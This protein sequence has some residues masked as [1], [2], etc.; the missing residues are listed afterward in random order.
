MLA[1][2]TPPR[3]PLTW[4]PTLYLAQ[5]LPFFAVNMVALQMFK[6][7]GIPNEDATFWL[8][9]IGFAWVFK[10]LWSP[11]LELVPTRKRVVVLFELIGGT[12]LG[13][14]ALA[15]HVPAYFAAC[16]AVLAV[17]AFA[18]ATHDIGADGIY[19]ASL[20]E[21]QQ[22]EY[23]GW[24]GA[25]FNAGKFIAS[26]GLLILAGNLEKTIGVTSAWTIIFI[27]IGVAMVGLG[28]YHAWALPP[29]P[30][31]ALVDRSAKAISATLWHVLLD[32]FRKPGI[33]LA[34]IFI[35][36]FRA[37]EAQV[38]TIGPLFLREARALG[39]L[40][41]TT[42]E[43]GGVYGTAGTVAF[44]LGSIGGGYFTARLGLKRAIFF[45]ILTMNL[46][47]LVFYY[48]S[49]VLPTDL[50]V[51]TVALSIEMFGYGFG[52]VGLILFMMQVVAV[53]KYQ[54]A[55][56]AF[57]TG[58]MQLGFV[59]FGMFSGKIQVALGYQHFFIWT[60][61]AAIPVLLLS[62]IMPIRARS[63]ADQEIAA[64]VQ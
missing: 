39:G 2:H 30:N 36:L 56:Y 3:N 57:A 40:G 42:A 29:A 45:L 8:R 18:A 46:P 62:L 7:T 41:M 28:L 47:N 21:K 1:Q 23:A 32:F 54:T 31:T 61:I 59:L 16:L 58:F 64:A 51:I 12:S 10:P 33:W 22:S 63:E 43:V 52:F 15:L 35:I 48:L 27:I 55:H 24:T 13:L 53:G 20:D 11:F 19:I 60:L 49:V 44:I 25:F 5:G 4:I 50:T 34:L 9:M 37:G 26:G 6:S 38:Q 14:V 17:A